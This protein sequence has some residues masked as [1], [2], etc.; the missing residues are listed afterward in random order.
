MRKGSLAALAQ[1]ER[2]TRSGRM[3]GSNASGLLQLLFVI[4]TCT[5]PRGRAGAKQLVQHPQQGGAAT[6]E[7]AAK[8]AA[9]R[10]QQLALRDGECRAA[11]S[12]QLG[13]TAAA[14]ESTQESASASSTQ[15]QKVH[16]GS[17]SITKPEDSSSSSNSSIRAPKRLNLIRITTT[18]RIEESRHQ[19]QQQDS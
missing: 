17:S 7:E 5:L 10:Q 13:A 9:G 4:A 6:W 1:E 8:R 12:V 3:G 19:V 11:C 14:A 2:A 15:Q 16:K 18:S